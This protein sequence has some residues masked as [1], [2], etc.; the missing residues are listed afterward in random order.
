M[1]GKGGPWAFPNDCK[2]YA[3]SREFFELFLKGDGQQVKA[4]AGEKKTNPEHFNNWVKEINATK[5]E[6]CDDNENI[7]LKYDYKVEMCYCKNEKDENGNGTPCNGKKE[8]GR[9]KTIG[10][11]KSGVAT[12]ALTIV[13]LAIS[14]IGTYKRV[15]KG[16]FN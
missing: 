2:D 12:L 3:I 7:E 6:K 8:N 5:A 11:S 1:P 16:F 4:S 13:L 15:L 10:V 14:I 9:W